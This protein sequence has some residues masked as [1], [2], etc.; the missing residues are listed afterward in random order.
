MRAPPMRLPTQGCAPTG[1][2]LFGLILG[3]GIGNPAA[4]ASIAPPMLDITHQ[5]E[6]GGKRSS[7][8]MSECVV[9][10]S[11]ARAEILQKWNSV[12]DASAEKCIKTGRKG[13]KMPYTSIARCLSNEAS[14]APPP[15]P[16]PPEAGKNASGILPSLSCAASYFFS[17]SK[18]AKGGS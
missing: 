6:T 10:E 18:C 12:S 5:C 11:E 1:T 8:A 17:S 16:T 13:K 4:A 3:I 7:S 14:I 2:L 9:A 15:V